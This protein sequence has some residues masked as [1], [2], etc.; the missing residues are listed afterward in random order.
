MTSTCH[1]GLG[2]FRKLPIT[3]FSR[4]M[5]VRVLSYGRSLTIGF[6]AFFNDIQNSKSANQSHLLLS[7]V[8][9]RIWR[10]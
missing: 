10:L 6:F 3:C 2:R 4:S 1:R 9:Q 5:F 7:V 8:M